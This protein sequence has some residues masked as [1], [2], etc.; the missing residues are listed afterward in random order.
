MKSFCTSLVVLAMCLGA[1]T[2]AA[3]APAA[4]PSGAARISVEF[5][6]P[7]REALHQLANKG[8]INLLVTEPLDNEAQ[9][10]LHDVTAE[11]ALKS[12]AAAYHLKLEQADGLWTVRRGPPAP[13]PIKSP[14]P[15]PH[16]AAPVVLAP[17][18]PTPPTPPV[19]PLPPK[20][21]AVPQVTMHIDT[22]GEET[23]QD[24]DEDEDEHEDET[25]SED[26]DAVQKL[27]EQ[28]DKIGEAAE[29][30]VEADQRKVE[31][32]QRRIEK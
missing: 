11:Q 24:A 27:E 8:H 19:P 21:P 9:V 17:A 23:E 7:L 25:D 2:L 10:Y 26:A 16:L 12:V 22:D 13:V 31:A 1:P 3:E 15:A 18:A 4:A 32:A 14:A 6:G 30:K 29:R 20:A 5:R 28:T